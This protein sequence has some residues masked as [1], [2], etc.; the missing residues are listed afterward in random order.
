MKLGMLVNT[1]KNLDAVVGLTKAA[2]AKGHEVVIF[3]MDEGTTLFGNPDY[4]ALCGMNGVSMSFCDHSA[5][6]IG[7]PTQGL[8]ASVVCGSQYNN[9]AMNHDADKV[10]VL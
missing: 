3:T 10:I 2:L 6:G 9:A 7:A 5:K 1:N 8:S 4:T